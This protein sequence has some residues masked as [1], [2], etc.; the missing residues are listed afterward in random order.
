MGELARLKQLNRDTQRVDEPPNGF[1]A[2]LSRHGML[3]SQVI[4][5]LANLLGKPVRLGH[6]GSAALNR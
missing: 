6:W 3:R 5:H 2:E 1:D 4:W